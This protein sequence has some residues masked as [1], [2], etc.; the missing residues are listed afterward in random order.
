MISQDHMTKGSSNMGKSPFI[1]NDDPARFGGHKHYSSGDIMTL[2]CH[3]ILQVHVMKG[4]RDF[5]GRSPSR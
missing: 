2:V 5:M 1:V 4:S 3:M